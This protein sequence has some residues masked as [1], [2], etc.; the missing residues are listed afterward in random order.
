MNF[1][2][3]P[4]GFILRFLKKKKA[5]MFD[6]LHSVKDKATIDRYLGADGKA[7]LSKLKAVLV[8]RKSLTPEAFDAALDSLTKDGYIEKGELTEKG[9][10]KHD[11]DCAA[12][13]A[14]MTITY[15]T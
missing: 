12:Y 3:S 6:S 11:A 14:N 8:E 13:L 10:E 9:M 2:D 4:E 7:D 15:P 5:G 1:M